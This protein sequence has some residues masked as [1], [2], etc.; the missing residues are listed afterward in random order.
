M[1]NKDIAQSSET[2][3][4]LGIQIPL[5]LDQIWLMWEKCK[6]LQDLIFDYVFLLPL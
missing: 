6:I 3:K 4:L 2:K 5:T 1:Q